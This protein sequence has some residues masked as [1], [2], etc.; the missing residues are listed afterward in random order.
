MYIAL[1]TTIHLNVIEVS[2]N[3]STPMEFDVPLLISE[4]D[5]EDVHWDLVTRQV[6]IKWLFIQNYKELFLLLTILCNYKLF[7]RLDYIK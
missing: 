4:I 7:L 3:P 6:N 5:L 2:R 1:G